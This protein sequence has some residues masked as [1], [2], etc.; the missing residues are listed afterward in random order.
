M[1]KEKL[2]ASRM[3]SLMTCPR[4]HYYGYEVGLKATE[5]STAL[6]IGTAMHAGLEARANG[7]TFDEAYHVAI[8]SGSLDPFMAATIYGL[9][10]AYYDR[11]ANTDAISEMLPEIE[12]DHAIERSMAFTAAGK[13]D[14]LAVLCDGRRAL[15]EHKTTGESIAE[16]SDYWTRLRFNPQL[17]QYVLAAEREGYP[18]ETVVYDVIRKPAIKPLEKKPTLDADGL[19][20]VHGPNGERVYKRDGTPKQT[21]D[22]AKGEYVLTAPETAQEYALRVYEDAMARP[23]FYFARREVPFTDDQLEEFKNS[24]LAICRML[25]HY[26]GQARH[27]TRPELGWP[28]NVSDRCTMCEYQ[29][30]CL[31]G[32]QVDADH[33]PAGFVAGQANCELK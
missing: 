13:I 25:L 5:P 1:Q 8:S 21:A 24:R 4:K 3:T 30:F 20:Q 28:R 26:K 33:V 27:A 2:T 10:R 15:V 11:Y 9:L 22:A 31:E 7:E 32:V 14:G 19:K 23:D 12:F 16:T 6:R 17:F 18:V 29:G